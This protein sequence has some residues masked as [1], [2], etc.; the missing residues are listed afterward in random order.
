MKLTYQ[1][2]QLLF[3]QLIR[4]LTTILI[5]FFLKI[6]LFIKILL[7]IF[8]DTFDCALPHFIFK[9]WSN[10]KKKFYQYTDK[11]TD[12]ICYSILLFYTIKNSKMSILNKKLIFFLFII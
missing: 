8:T 7:I 1:N 4:I 12:I 9:E 5:L 6:P 3:S 2:K 11:L 10:C